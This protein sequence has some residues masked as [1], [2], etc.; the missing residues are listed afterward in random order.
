MSP[1]AADNWA[2]AKEAVQRTVGLSTAFNTLR[3]MQTPAAIRPDQ[4]STIKVLGQGAFARVDAC[5]YT[6]DGGGKPYIVAVKRLKLELFRNQEDLDLFLKEVELMRKLRHSNIVDF[7]GA[8]E[9]K[10]GEVPGAFACEFVV[11][12]YMA[13]GTL[14][15][16]VTKDMLGNGRRT[17]S[18]ADALDI[19]LQMARGLRYLHKSRPMVIHRDLKLE[20]VLLASATPVHGKF[21]VKLADFGLSRRVQVKQQAIN[22]HKTVSG[23]RMQA[24]VPIPAKGVMTPATSMQRMKS[25]AADDLEEQWNVRTKSSFIS[26][27]PPVQISLG[28]SEP[29][30]L[31]FVNEEE[32][33]FKLTGRTGSLMYMA[34]EVFKELPYSEKADVFSFGTM[35]YEVLQRYIMLSAVAVRGTYEELEAYCARV[36]DGYRPPLHAK[37]PPSIVKL[38]QDC[39]AQEPMERPTMDEVVTRLESIQMSGDMEALDKKEPGCTCTIC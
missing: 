33:A 38:I 31:S 8:G 28:A 34:P 11:Q 18:N 13:G 21:V 3:D 14:K 32:S 15:S 10:P 24:S 16:L 12:E 7:V 22:L 1:F 25:G 2:K 20:N 9:V 35:M 37:W 30:E 19:S 26:S 23:M 17:Y 6:P 39:W 29:H 5:M 4:L 36:A 27:K